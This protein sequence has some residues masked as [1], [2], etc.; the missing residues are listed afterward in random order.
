[1]VCLLYCFCARAVSAMESGAEARACALQGMVQ[2][3]LQSRW[4]CSHGEP[5]PHLQPSALTIMTIKCELFSHL[6]GVAES[7]C[8]KQ[9]AIFASWRSCGIFNAFCGLQPAS[10]PGSCL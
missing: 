2:M 3:W 6:H 10:L 1:M 9:T 4:C 5:H 8:M 7:Q